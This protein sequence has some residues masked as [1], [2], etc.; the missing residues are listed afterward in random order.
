MNGSSAKL[1]TN[2]TTY[3]ADFAN[4]LVEEMLQINQ[5]GNA[6]VYRTTI[7]R[8][9]AFASNLRL[10]FNDIDYKLLDGFKRH[11]L[12]EGIKPNTI[13]NYFRTLSAIYNKAIKAKLADRSKYPSL[14][15]VFKQ[16]RTGFSSA[17]QYY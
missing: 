14:D 15:I 7:N 4:L 12:K 10:R 5:T 11:L 9:T 16:E 3:F 8:F 17:W 1:Q 2:N 13:S 6:I